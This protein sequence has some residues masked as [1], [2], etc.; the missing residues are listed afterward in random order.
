VQQLGDMGEWE[1]PKAKGNG[2]NNGNGKHQM[3]GKIC[4]LHC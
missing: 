1:T 4:L 2:G 3:S